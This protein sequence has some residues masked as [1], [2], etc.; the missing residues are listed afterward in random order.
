MV[1]VSFTD[2][3]HLNEYSNSRDKCFVQTVTGQDEATIENGANT[4]NTDKDTLAMDL[5]HGKVNFVSIQEEDDHDEIILRPANIE[6]VDAVR[7]SSS[8]ATINTVSDEEDHDQV[9]VNGSP[10]TN[11][12]LRHV[13]S[14]PY[15]SF[16]PASEN[17]IFAISGN[18]IS[19]I[20][21]TPEIPSIS[22][23]TLPKNYEDTPTIEKYKETV[24]LH[25]IQTANSVRAAQLDF[26]M[27]RHFRRSDL[28]VQSADNLVEKSGPKKL[29]KS[30]RL[31]LIRKTLP[32]LAIHINKEKSKEKNIE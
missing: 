16:R 6:T 30:K 15:F 3:L 5:H 7:A 11:K 4:T 21:M 29:E 14:V 22:F 24:S 25:S 2:R 19:Q 26:S 12:R 9:R 28:I 17:D 1:V 27:P 31:K 20:S 10:I 13:K 32:P 18:S 8:H 23:S